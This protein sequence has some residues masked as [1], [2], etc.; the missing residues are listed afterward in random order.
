MKIHPA[1]ITALF[2]STFFTS[3]LIG[4]QRP[5]CENVITSL[6]MT[7]LG[8]EVEHE[9]MLGA[10]PSQ[11]IDEAPLDAYA[12]RLHTDVT[13]ESNEGPCP[14]SY[15]TDCFSNISILAGNNFEPGTPAGTDISTHFKARIIHPTGDYQ[16]DYTD[17][18]NAVRHIC[19]SMHGTDEK[20]MVMHLLLIAPPSD[21]GKYSFEVLLDYGNNSDTLRTGEISLQ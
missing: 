12:I 18:K 10:T 3:C 6:A 7:P 8:W 14:A 4:E 11:V 5:P 19:M 21:P 17:L 13:I 9:S 20:E 15:M 1:L 2:L 16:W